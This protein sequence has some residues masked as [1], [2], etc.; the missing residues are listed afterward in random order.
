MKCYKNVTKT[1]Y[2]CG[3]GLIQEGTGVNTKCYKLVTTEK[4]TYSCPSDSTSNNGLTGEKLRCYKTVSGEKIPYCAN[5][6]AVIKNNKCVLTIPSVFSHYTCPKGY[7]LN[8]KNGTCSRDIIET[9]NATETTKQVKSTE[10]KWSRSK[11][12]EGWTA[13]G[14]TRTV[15]VN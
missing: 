7:K 4:V 9:I 6:N 10:T 14:R 5:P 1:E 13:T 2:S 15:K 11:V 12:L 8:S 3:A